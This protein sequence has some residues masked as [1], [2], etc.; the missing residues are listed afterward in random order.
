[1][2]RYQIEIR[3]VVT[4][5]LTAE[6]AI[7]DIP[8]EHGLILIRVEANTPERARELVGKAISLAAQRSRYP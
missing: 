8:D 4:Q 3:G 7:A 1:M 5:E 6:G 2:K